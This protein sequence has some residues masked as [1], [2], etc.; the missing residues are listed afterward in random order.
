[1][2]AHPGASQRFLQKTLLRKLSNGRKQLKAVATV[3][4][5]ITQVRRYHLQEGARL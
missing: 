3:R 1:M 5:L 2:Y 4:G